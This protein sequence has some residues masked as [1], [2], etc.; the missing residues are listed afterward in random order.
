MMHTNKTAHLL[1]IHIL[2]QLL[3]LCMIMGHVESLVRHSACFKSRESG[4]WDCSQ[5]SLIPLPMDHTWVARL[6]STNQPFIKQGKLPLRLFIWRPDTY[7]WD[8]NSPQPF[9]YQALVSWKTI[10]PGGDGFRIIQ[11]H[12][13]LC[14]YENLM[15]PLIRKEAELRQ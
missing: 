7:V 8:A 1:H 11:V 10:F 6:L 15:A 9:W 12:L 2:E 14:S 3:R 5:M 13:N 4:A